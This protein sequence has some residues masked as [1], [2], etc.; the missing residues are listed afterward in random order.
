[1]MN[2]LLNIRKVKLKTQRNV[3]KKPTALL[4]YLPSKIRNIG[5]VAHVDA[6]KTTI[7]ERLL[8]L[9]GITN[10][11]GD[12]DKGNT[13][14]DFLDLER[15]RGITIQSAALTFPWN[16]HRINLIDTPGHVDFTMEVERCLRVLDGVVI[17]LDGSAGVQA[18]TLK[19]FEQAK[20]FKVPSI[21]F[22]NKLDK[23]NANFEGTLLSIKE[24]LGVETVN[25]TVPFGDRLEYVVDLLAGTFLKGD[26]WKGIN[27]DKN[28]ALYDFYLRERE[29][30]VCKIVEHN[31][32][33]SEKLLG[34]S[35]NTISNTELKKELRRLTL[36]RK[37]QPLAVGSALNSTMSVLPLLDMVTDYLPSPVEV[38]VMGTKILKKDMSSLIFKISHDDRLGQLSYARV[39]TGSL[40]GSSTVFN[41]NKGVTE[42]KIKLFVPYSDDL[43]AVSEVKAGNIAVITG[44][45]ETVTGETLLESEECGKE[46]LINLQKE[47]SNADNFILESPETNSEQFKKFERALAELCIEDPSMKIRVDKNTGE[48]VLEAMGELHLEVIKDRLSRQYGLKVFFG[49]LQV[50]YREVIGSESSSASTIEDSFGESK[51]KQFVNISLSIEPNPGK[52]FKSVKVALPTEAGQNKTSSFIRGDWLKAINAGC[53][54]GLFNGPLLGFPVEEVGITLNV[55]QTSG[56]KMNNSLISA[57]ANDCVKK[58]LSKVEVKLMEP[59]VKVEVAL[60]DDAATSSVGNVLHELTNRRGDIINV[61]DEGEA[62]KKVMI[63]CLM[64]LIETTGLSRTIRSAASGMASFTVTFEGYQYV[65]EGETKRLCGNTN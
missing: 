16:E 60:I 51:R 6:G 41:S 44:L 20:E 10:I 34:T 26:D 36:A 39:Y 23:A 30:C 58:M 32:M 1:M 15:E 27:K 13:V 25:L 5:V 61:E 14:T 21:Y 49:P 9:S 52:K 64:P 47:V 37:L 33:L 59:Y 24:K 28:G 7:T 53:V 57:A 38:N 31:E 18:Q 56:A 11:C 40:R 8:Y 4:N 46:A 54:N 29:N 19:V 43:V 2:A 45:K 12:V 17:V 63:K 48:T 62:K 42:S 35:N 65:S 22:V 50:N 3:M 55:F